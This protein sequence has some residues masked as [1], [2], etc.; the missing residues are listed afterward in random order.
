M[1][2]H[3]NARTCLHSRWLIVERVLEQGWSVAAAAEA[4]GVSERRR[5]GWPATATRAGTGLSIAP[6]HRIGSLVAHLLSECV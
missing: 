1:R 6:R 3:G 4:A 5:S 2:F